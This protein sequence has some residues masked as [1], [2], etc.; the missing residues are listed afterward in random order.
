VELV[1]DWRLARVYDAEYSIIDE[2]VWEGDRS[3]ASTIRRLKVL[4]S[5]RMTDEANILHE[6]FPEAKKSPTT[7]I[8]NWPPLDNKELNLLQKSSLILAEQEILD[9]AST[10]DFRLEHLV[11]VMEES[12]NVANN[13]ESQLTDWIGILLPGVNIDQHRSSL[14]KSI[15]NSSNWDKF[16]DGFG[17][18][19]RAII[20]SGEWDSIQVLSEQIILAQS[21]L[22]IIEGSVKELTNSYLPSLSS[23][24]GP[25]IAAQLCVAAH[26]RERL[27]RLPASTIQVLGAEKSFF[28]HLQKGTNPPKHGYIFQHTW[29]SR[30]PKSTRGSIA[31]ML[32]AKAAIAVRIDCYGGEP[33]GD[34]ER[35]KVEQKVG[36]IRI[37]KR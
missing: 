1:W 18:I 34:K 20:Q 33:W 31:R 19:P 8:V 9:A 30:S 21:S 28:S 22:N 14:A 6:R 25:S 16:V 3:I 37:R 26:G 12:R 5:G 23:L 27:A 10:P 29:I 17:D 32:A 2:L 24:L 11:R 35:S 36:E 4:K 7:T 15:S 13:L